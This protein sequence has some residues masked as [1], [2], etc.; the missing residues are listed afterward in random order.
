MCIR[1][2]FDHHVYVIA[3][4]GD[5]MEGVTAEASSLAGHQQLGNLTLVYDE[6]YISIEDDTNVSFSEDVAKRYESY[7]WDVRVV[8]WRAS[9][10][11]GGKYTEDVD[12]LFEAIEEGKKVTDK[13]SIVI[14]R[15]IIA[16]PAP[17]KQNTGKAHG[18]ALGEDEIKATKELLGFDP[19]QTFE[20]EDAVIA[21]TRKAIQR[22][23]AAL[24]L[25]HI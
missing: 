17:T 16:Y 22:G 14:L 3:S 15:T 6:N 11:D 9:A 1:D 21:H 8:D 12:A 4:D 18:S 19:E 23:Q 24:S 2:R 10:K 7:G 13:P 25:I 20:V 5:I